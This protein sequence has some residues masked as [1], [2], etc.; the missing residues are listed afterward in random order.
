MVVVSFDY[1][2]KMNPRRC[3]NIV[4]V[5]CTLQI[6]D[7]LIM[8]VLMLKIQFVVTKCLYNVLYWIEMADVH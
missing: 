4:V 1:E 3:G 8:L 5:L 2:A 7:D 6:S